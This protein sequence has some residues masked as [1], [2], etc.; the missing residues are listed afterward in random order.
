MNGFLLGLI[1]SVIGHLIEKYIKQR[2]KIKR[3]CPLL[4]RGT[5]Y[6]IWSLKKRS[7]YAAIYNE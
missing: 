2:L 7:N 3:D 5:P 1:G 4:S 6:Y